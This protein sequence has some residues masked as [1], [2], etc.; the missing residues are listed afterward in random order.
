MA[1]GRQLDCTT[2]LAQ[3]TN[4][5]KSETNMTAVK[6]KTPRWDT[7]KAGTQG[8]CKALGTFIIEE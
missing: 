1:F 5:N 3:K 7:T 4:E 2:S 8:N 6:R